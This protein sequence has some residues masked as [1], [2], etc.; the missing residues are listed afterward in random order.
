MLQRI[1]KKMVDLEQLRQIGENT[2]KEKRKEKE[3]G[4]FPFLREK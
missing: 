3:K 1:K 4:K 2:D